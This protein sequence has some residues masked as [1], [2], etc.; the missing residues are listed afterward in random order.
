MLD[1]STVKAANSWL[2]YTR[3]KANTHAVDAL[4]KNDILFPYSLRVLENTKAVLAKTAFS[5]LQALKN[6]N[7]DMTR[8]R[9]T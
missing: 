9:Y 7:A 8:P 1:R 6:R 2:G 5:D 4:Y 3:S